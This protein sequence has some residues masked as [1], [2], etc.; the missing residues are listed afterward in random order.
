MP[1]VSQRRKAALLF[2]LDG[3]LVDSKP[4]I[5]RCF[6]YALDELQKPSPSE[7]VLV[8]S[9]GQPF[10]PA[11]AGFLDTSDEHL[12]EQAVTL[13]RNRYGESGL[14]EATIYEGVPDMLL[15]LDN[16]TA[17]I[18]TSK[19]TVYAS[20]II[21]HF[22]LARY[23]RNVYGP[24]L[25]GKLGDKTE[26]VKHLLR[27]EQI[28]G[29]AVMIG[30]RADDMLA[31]INNGCRAVGVLWGYGSKAELAGAGAQVLCGTPTELAKYLLSM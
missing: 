30:D 24:D 27:T 2:D 25:N 22:G 20:R 8:A 29:D 26:L 23:F 6:R 21:Q 5:V 15:A 31:A 19:A 13:Y 16:Q 1:K 7:D 4:G 28:S 14:Y 11:F 18:A 12:I 17:Y 9:I 10:R 3:T